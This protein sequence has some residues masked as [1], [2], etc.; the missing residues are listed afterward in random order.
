VVILDAR[1]R[2]L[3]LV[4]VARM[5]GQMTTER[6]DALNRMFRVGSFALVLVNAF[7]SR[8]ELQELFVEPPWRTSAWFTD[9][10]GHMIHFDTGCNS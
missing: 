5:R 8:R 4:D 7:A 1:H 6:R 2:W 3:V 10:P 9:E